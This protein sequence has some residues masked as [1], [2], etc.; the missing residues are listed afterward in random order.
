MGSCDMP[1]AKVP[2]RRATSRLNAK[3]DPLHVNLA[4]L[5]PR[6]GSV[7]LTDTQEK[8]DG[9]TTQTVGLLPVPSSFLFGTGSGPVWGKI[10]CV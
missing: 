3:G 9:L 7:A 4:A 10:Y 8:L 1:D 2:A 6:Y 5:E